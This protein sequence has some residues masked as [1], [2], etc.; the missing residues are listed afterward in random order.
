[1]KLFFAFI[2]IFTAVINLNL[3][4]VFAQEEKSVK[5]LTSFYPVYI[6]ALNVIKDVPG[7]SVENLTPPVTGCLHDYSLTTADMKKVA[8]ADVFVANGA[9]MESFLDNV[10][11]R[12]PRLKVATL[13]EGVTFIKEGKEVNP[14]VWVSLLNAIKEVNNL[15]KDIEI[16]D[17]SHAEL[18]RKN[19]VTYVSKLEALREK[20]RLELAPF[21]GMQIITF[22]EA[23]SYFAQEFGFKIAAVIE[24]NPGSEPSAKELAQTIDM[25]KQLGIKVLFSEPQYSAQSAE[26]IS[27]ETGAKV[28][29]LDPA[30]TGPKDADAYIKIME[31]NLLVLK[32]AFLAS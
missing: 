1:M 2:I 24:R 32:Q 30:V 12:Y 28:Y 11:S 13:A 21:K 3:G 15:G 20:M 18:Y 31:E 8:S 22:H 26:M 5:V 17:P 29:I 9:G 7:V 10:I 14:H 19:T 25:I 23:F 6:M 4:H 27:K 16:F